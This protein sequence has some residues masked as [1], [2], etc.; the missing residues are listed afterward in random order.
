MDGRREDV[1]RSFAD[2]R[3]DVAG[4]SEGRAGVG[5]PSCP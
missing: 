3:L 2:G 4:D 5:G 1:L